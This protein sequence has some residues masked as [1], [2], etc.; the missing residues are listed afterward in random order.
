MSKDWDIAEAGIIQTQHR[1]GLSSF[2][3]Y[4]IYKT[5]K[6]TIAAAV[7]AQTEVK[8]AQHHLH[9]NCQKQFVFTLSVIK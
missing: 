6:K 9:E 1:T 4:F 7:A 5:R 8:L 3:K 2:P